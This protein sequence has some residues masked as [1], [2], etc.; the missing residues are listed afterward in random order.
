MKD[1][2]Y[3]KESSRESD[4]QS[5][6]NGVLVIGD[7]TQSTTIAANDASHE[8]GYVTGIKLWSLLA[9]LTLVLFL[10]MLD[11]SIVVTVSFHCS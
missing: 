3:E 10:M 8:L 5:D 2:G 4:T 9:A 1:N 11:M 6:I 7:A